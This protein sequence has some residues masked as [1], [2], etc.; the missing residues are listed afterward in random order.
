MSEQ[1]KYSRH[2]QHPDGR[3]FNVSTVRTYEG[4][5]GNNHPIGSPFQESDYSNETPW[6]FETMIFKEVGAAG[7]YHK[8]AASKADALAAHTEAVRLIESGEPFEGIGVSGFWGTPSTT[9][10][11]WASHIADNAL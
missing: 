3:K 7:Q 10:Q 11:Q 1:I 6:P 5:G 4:G 2:V 9:P 8:P